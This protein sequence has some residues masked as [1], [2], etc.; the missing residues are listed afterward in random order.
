[1]AMRRKTSTATSPMF[2]FIMIGDS[3]TGK[4]SLL[5]RYTKNSFAEEYNVTIGMH[6]HHSGI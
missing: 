4:S 2:K 1:M 6:Y 3:G 5:I